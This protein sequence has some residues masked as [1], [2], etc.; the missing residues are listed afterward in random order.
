MRAMSR[1]Q[2]V[3]H[4]E[5][6]ITRARI[7]LAR[8]RTA[9]NDACSCGRPLPCPQAETLTTAVHHYRAQLAIAERT[10]HL[11]TIS[12]TSPRRELSWW[13]RLRAVF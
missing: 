13:Q 1:Q 12:Y 10:M 3:E 11:P 5:K 9:G 8:H 2:F 6:E 7:I 4:A